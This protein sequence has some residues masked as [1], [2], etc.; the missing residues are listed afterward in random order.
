ME[1]R[2]TFAKHPP[3]AIV[4][5][6]FYYNTTLHE[7]E[8]QRWDE[9]T[10]EEERCWAVD[11]KPRSTA[12]LVYSVA[13]ECFAFCSL[14]FLPVVPWTPWPASMFNLV[15]GLLGLV[16]GMMRF[17][18]LKSVRIETRNRS[19]TPWKAS[20]SFCLT[21]NPCFQKSNEYAIQQETKNVTNYNDLTIWLNYRGEI[22]NQPIDQVPILFPEQGI[23]LCISTDASSLPH[24]NTCLYTLILRTYRDTSVVLRSSQRHLVPIFTILL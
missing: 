14:N 9:Q 18:H 23:R 1:L 12:K 3:L 22:Q 16:F 20:F 5:L 11:N 7:T 21:W 13:T 2:V 6:H 15:D 19:L 8:D 10:Q 24:F 17:C 4:G